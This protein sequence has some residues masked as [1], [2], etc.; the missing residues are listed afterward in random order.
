[1]KSKTDPRFWKCFNELPADIQEL[2]RRQ[3]NIWRKRPF[4]PALHFKELRPKL[5]SVRVSQKYR[6]LAR[7]MVIRWFGFGSA[8][9]TVTIPGFNRPFLR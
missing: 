5:W 2:A 7:D 1:V 8:R 6:A 4:H 3:F 9:T